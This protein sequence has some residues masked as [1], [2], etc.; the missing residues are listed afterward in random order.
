MVDGLADVV[1]L[2]GGDRIGGNVF[3]RHKLPEASPGSV[4]AALDAAADRLGIAADA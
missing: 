1:K 2:R 3:K 4:V